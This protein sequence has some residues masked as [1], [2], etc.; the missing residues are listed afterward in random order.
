[1]CEAQNSIKSKFGFFAFVFDLFSFEVLAS[2]L[3]FF[4]G[5]VGLVMVGVL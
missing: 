5:S 3:L 4:V 1:M 2:S